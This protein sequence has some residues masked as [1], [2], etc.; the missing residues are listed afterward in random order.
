MTGKFCGIWQS[1]SDSPCDERR[2]CSECE[3]LRDKLEAASAA[4]DELQMAHMRERLQ[5]LEQRLSFLERMHFV[6]APLIMGGD[7]P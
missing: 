6:S 4:V 2:A 1:D 5:A 7:E 3:D